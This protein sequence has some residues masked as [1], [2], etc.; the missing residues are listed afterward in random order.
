MLDTRLKDHKYLAGDYSIADIANWSWVRIHD[1]AAVE[2]DDLPH[3]RRWMDTLA[4]R[5]ACQRGVL[6][7][8]PFEPDAVV[9]FAKKILTK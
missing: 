7:P 4:A 6:I 3:L 8:E 2:A 5:P 9:N 1:W